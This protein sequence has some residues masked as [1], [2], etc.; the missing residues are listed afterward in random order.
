MNLLSRMFCFTCVACLAASVSYAETAALPTLKRM[1]EPELRQ[2]SG[3]IPFQEDPE[4]R[5]SLE[6]EIMRKE[7]DIVNYSAADHV[8]GSYEYQ[9]PAPVPDMSGIPLFLQQHITNIATG[10]QSSDP[11]EGLYIM[12]QPLGINRGNLQEIRNGSKEINLNPKF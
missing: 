4:V 10:L 1:A 9:K 11:T 3:V 8:I 5:Q 12:L 6:H 2:Q 7:R